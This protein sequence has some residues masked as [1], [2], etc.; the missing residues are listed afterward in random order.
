VPVPNFPEAVLLDKFFV[1]LDLIR[2]DDLIC[3]FLFSEIA[4]KFSLVL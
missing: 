3:I 4:S 2:R 1:L